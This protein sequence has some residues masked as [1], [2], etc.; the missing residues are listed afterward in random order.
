V[1]CRENVPVSGL[2]NYRHDVKMMLAKLRASCPQF[3]IDG[4]QNV[5]IV[6]PG[7]KSRGRGKRKILKLQ[8][9]VAGKLKHRQN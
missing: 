2:E 4:T 9:P 1:C 5:W 6:K 7:A 3:D 8:Y